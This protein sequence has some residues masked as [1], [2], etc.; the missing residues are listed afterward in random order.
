[1]FSHSCVICVYFSGTPL[2]PLNIV[3]PIRRARDN[4]H[5]LFGH[6]KRLNFSN[7]SSDPT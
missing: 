6:V 1:M 7:L 2:R 4:I 3:S 5:R